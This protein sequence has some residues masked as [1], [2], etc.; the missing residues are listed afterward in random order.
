MMKRVIEYV[1]AAIV[2]IG[3]WPCLLILWNLAEDGVL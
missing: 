1:I 3:F 2:T